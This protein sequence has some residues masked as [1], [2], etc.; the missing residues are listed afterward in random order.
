MYTRKAD[1]RIPKGVPRVPRVRFAIVGNAR[2]G[3]SHLVSLLDSHPDIACWDDEIFDVGEAF[4]TSNYQDARQFLIEKVFDLYAD[5]VGFKLLWDA[6][7]HT[8]APW[9]WIKELDI[10]LVH[11]RR[12]NLLDT[13]MSFQLA[14]INQAF[15]SWKGDYKIYQFEADIDQ[16]R[17][18]FEAAEACDRAIRGRCADDDIPRM[19]IEYEELC[20]NQNRVLEFLTVSSAPLMSELKKQRKGIQSEIIT[21]YVTLKRGFSST[22]WAR[23]FED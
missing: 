11:T 8:T 22:R 6:L 14:T 10:K 20:E 1:P 23:H 12:E 4:D 17:E 3:S 5:A 13:Y 9:S 21:N 15:T 2:T 16:C 19:E 18:F 7:N